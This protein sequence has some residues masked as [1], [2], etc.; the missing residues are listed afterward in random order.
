M[1]KI[2]VCHMTADLVKHVAHATGEA[3][4]VCKDK[5]RQAL[6]LKVADGLGRLVGRVGIPHLRSQHTDRYIY[7]T[8]RMPH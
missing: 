1:S 8:V 3:A 7:T 2:D 6:A 5:E 4:P